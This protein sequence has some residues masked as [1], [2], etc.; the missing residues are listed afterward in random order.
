MSYPDFHIGRASDLEGSDRRLYRFFEILPGALAWL[1]IGLVVLF[2]WLKPHWIAFFI[3]AFDFYWIVK[4]A[5]LSAHLRVNWKK[6][7]QNLKTD[8]EEKLN[9]L[10]WEHIWQMV[11]LPFYKEDYEVVKSTV[12]ALASADYPKDKMIVVLGAEERAGESALAVAERIKNEYAGRFAHFFIAKHPQNLAGEMPGKGSNSSWAA[13]KAKEEILDKNSIPYEDVLVSSFDIDTRVY[14]KYFLCLTY[15]F[16]TCEH[17]FRSSFQPVPLYN[18]NIWE[19]PALSRVVGTSGTFWQMI[20]QE[21]PE[22][23]VSFSSHAMNF[24]TLDEI[25]YWQK[26]MV[27]EDSRIFWNA[28]MHFNGDYRVVPLA[29]PVSMDAN[30]AP[31]L[32]QTAKNVYKQQRRWTWGVENIAYMLFGFHKKK[33]EI[34]LRKRL[35]F[36]FVQLEGFWSLSTNALMIFILGWLPLWI[37]GQVF[38]DTLLSYNLPRITRTLMTIAMLGLIVSAIISTT[39]LPPKPAQYKKKKYVSMIIQW[40]LIPFTII[41]FSSFPGLETQTRLMLGKY[42]GFWVTP[43][44]S[45][46]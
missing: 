45:K 11:V 35:H 1:T 18:N 39:L 14:P 3:I 44:Y 36:N 30:L 32:A 33:K 5:F 4:T 2:S 29:Y 28:F 22:R 17:P 20:Q 46:K 42:M 25:G 34:P 15:N 8:W 7:K 26:N 43:K 38:N 6:M 16:L 24:K 9:N 19:A 40:L 37:G 10:K 12:E 31:K 41:V 27:S 21:R 13:Q 23:L